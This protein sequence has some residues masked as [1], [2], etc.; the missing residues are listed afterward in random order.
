VTLGQWGFGSRDKITSH[1]DFP[2][3]GLDLTGGGRACAGVYVYGRVNVWLWL[4]LWL[5]VC[6]GDM[7]RA[8][9]WVVG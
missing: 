3:E 7:L 9:C 6:L 1:V 5:C 2:V 8:V 4:W